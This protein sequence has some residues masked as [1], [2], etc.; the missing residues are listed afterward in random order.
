MIRQGWVGSVN[1][2]GP[3]AVPSTANRFTALAAGVKPSSS[4]WGI[5][6]VSGLEASDKVM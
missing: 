5:G 2:N 4:V 1:H 6:A 3:I